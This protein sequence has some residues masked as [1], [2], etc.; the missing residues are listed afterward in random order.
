MIVRAVL[1]VTNTGPAP[2]AQII[3][4]HI[5]E[6][7]TR[8]DTRGRTDVI[9][10]PQGIAALAAFQ[11]EVEPVAKSGQPWTATIVLTDQFGCGHEARVEFQTF[12]L[13]VWA[14]PA[15]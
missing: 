1:H 7:F 11:F 10:F 6:P 15:V 8:T 5:K 12:G 2:L 14:T 4:A 13:R 9:S 3:G